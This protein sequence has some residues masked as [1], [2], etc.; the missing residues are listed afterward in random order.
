MNIFRSAGQ[1]HVLASA[2]FLG[3]LVN[4]MPTL[5]DAGAEASSGVPQTSAQSGVAAQAGE[6][7]QT[8]KQN[9]EP[10]GKIYVMVN[11]KPITVREYNQRLAY[12]VKAKNYH[13]RLRPEKAEAFRKEL[14]DEMVNHILQL[15]EVEKRGYKP[16]EAQIKKAITSEERKNWNNFAWLQDRVKLEEQLR[17]LVGQ[18]SQLDQLEAD[19]KDVAQPTP[20]EVRAYYDSHLDLFTE[21]EKLRLSVILIKV[22]PGA[23]DDVWKK[24]WDDVQKVAEQIKD[25]ADFADMARKYSNDATAINGGDMGY[26]HRGRVPEQ[27]QDGVDKFKVGEV[28]APYKGLEGVSVFRLEDRIPPDVKG[29]ERSANRAGDLLMRDK[30]EQAWKTFVERLHSAAKIEVITQPVDLRAIQP[31]GSEELMGK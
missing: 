31:T 5:A 17:T 10:V 6:S 18:K 16:D 25:G 29:F 22:D 4:A 20:A 19:V 14:T 2:L 11:G 30:R 7:T 27:I 12:E 28:S 13:G 8:D 21:P 1:R 15:E 23:P 3:M 26:L 9:S 24:A